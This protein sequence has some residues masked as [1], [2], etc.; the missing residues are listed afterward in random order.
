MGKTAAL[1]KLFSNLD[2]VGIIVADVDKAAAEF[3]SL[4]MGQFQLQDPGTQRQRWTRGKLIEDY[5]L[6]IRLGHVGPI[7]VELLEPVSGKESLH[8]E[9]VETTGGGIHHFAFVVDDIDEAEREMASA[10]YVQIFKSRKKGG[11][12][13]YFKSDRPGAVIYELLQGPQG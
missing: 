3:Q 11:G 13:G 10:G 12:A 9:F 1:Q 8:K 4:G 7:K 2:H 5:V 6:K